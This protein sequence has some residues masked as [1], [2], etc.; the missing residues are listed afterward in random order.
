[1]RYILAATDGS[2]DAERALDVAARLVGAL[3]GRLRIVHVSPYNL[4][5]DQIK[6]LGK[7]GISQG[8]ALEAFADR[9]L[10]KAR[11]RAQGFGLSDVRVQSCVGDPAEMLIEIARRERVDAIVMG[12]RGRGRLAGLLL[13]SVAQKLTNLAPCPV[14]HRERGSAPARGCS[15]QLFTWRRL[16][17]QGALTAAAAR[18]SFRRR[19]TG[20]CRA[21]FESCIDCSARRRWRRRSSKRRSNMPWAQ[22]NGCGCRRCRRRTVRDEESWRR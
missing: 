13:G 20:R 9:I 17:A 11:A 15:Y 10:T 4:S 14:R 7:L 22:K 12:R 1:M 19:I 21:R 8:E 6:H 18:R 3:Q 5:A 2:E 16:V